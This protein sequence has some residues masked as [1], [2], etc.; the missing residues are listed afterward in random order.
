MWWS[1]WRTPVGGAS[2]STTPPT[3]RRAA[4]MPRSS[5]WPGSYRPVSWMRSWPDTPMRRWRTWWPAY[6]SSRPMRGGRRSLASI[7]PSSPALGSCPLGSLRP[8]D[9]VRRL[10]RVATAKLVALHRRPTNLP[11]SNPTRPWWRRC[12]RNSSGSVAGARRRSVLRSRRPSPGI[13]MAWS[14]H[15]GTCL[16]M[17][18][19]LPCRRRTSRLAWGLGAAG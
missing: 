6:P 19:W 17:P 14:R 9:Y 5:D 18:S 8:R 16:R 3:C 15:L 4:T 12:G 2:G 7:S 10:T 13:E 1:C 11:R